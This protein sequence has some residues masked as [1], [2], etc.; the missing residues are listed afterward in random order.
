MAAGAF[1][2]TDRLAAGKS[3]PFGAQRRMKG[4][5]PGQ[6]LP[7]AAAAELAHLFHRRCHQLA[8]GLVRHTHHDVITV[9]DGDEHPRCTALADRR[10]HGRGDLTQQRIGDDDADGADDDVRP[11]AVDY[12]GI[13]A[14]GGAVCARLEHGRSRKAVGA[15]GGQPGFRAG[16]RDG[17]H[18]LAAKTAALPVND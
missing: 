2:F 11:A 9:V 4:T 1:I 3:P 6:R 10:R 18:Q 12:H 16:G 17:R 5:A 14:G 13:F 8:D 15:H 7:A